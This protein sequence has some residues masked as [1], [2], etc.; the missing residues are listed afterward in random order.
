M[1]NLSDEIQAKNIEL[2]F[3][4]YWDDDLPPILD[5]QSMLPCLKAVISNIDNNVYTDF[6][7][8][9]NG[10]ITE[11][12]NTFAPPYIFN[13][14]IEP[15]TFFNFK[16]NGALREIQI[17][18]LKYYCAF[19]LNSITVFDEVFKKIYNEEN[20]KKYI[21]NSNSYIIFN[22]NFYIHREYDGGTVEIES[23]E[24]AVKN[25]KNTGQLAYEENNARYLEKQG[26]H[27]Y[28][29]KVDIESF[30]PNI[31]T[32][33]LGKIKDMEPF[34]GEINCDEFFEFL[35]YYNMKV[36]NNQTKGIITGVFSSTISAELLMLCVDYDINKA[37]G[38][39]ASY[40]RYVDDLT[41]FSDSLEK[42][43]SKMP[44]VQKILNKY[45]LRINNSKTQERKSIYNTSYVDSYSIKEKF[46]F[47]DFDSA[48]DVKLDKDIFYSIKSYV[49]E[50]YDADEKTEIKAFLTLLKGAISQEK[51]VFDQ[52]SI[53]SEAVYLAFYM[54]QLACTEPLLVSR[55]Y[56]VISEILE[57]QK[58]QEGY[59][60]IIN[61]LKNKRGFINDT[62]HDSILQIWHYY[63]LSK[64]DENLDISN[65]IT[66]FNES[67]VNPLILSMLVRTGNDTNKDIIKY[68][69]D[70][71]FQVAGNSNE[72][73]S[74]MNTV[75]FSKWWL[76]LF[77][78]YSKDK[79]DYYGFYSSNHFHLIY[80]DMTN[81]I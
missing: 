41:F 2:L 61:E 26:S 44:M 6:V 80:K 25:N 10:V 54:I 68:I 31:Y 72:P 50:K 66:D 39:N 22:R 37:I 75:M 77:S 48:E 46:I 53:V 57:K 58:G 7:K 63:I 35:D 60:K 20:F 36:N 49:S 9:S 76:P 45:R 34:Q 18:N 13:D 79:K 59:Q 11:F 55:S 32:H 33:Y 30:Y 17:P 43:H 42:I 70:R 51:L 19:V 38:S 24:F 8:N 23:G 47:F 40:I 3:E 27:L 1:I 67:E 71:Y 12:S 52:E 28:S 15:I 21:A 5:I 73:N 74:W 16:K 14:G 4:G 69:K 29:V 65:Y 81:E 56:K 64:Y 78:I 62:Y